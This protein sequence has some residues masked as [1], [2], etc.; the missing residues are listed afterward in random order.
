MEGV[1]IAIIFLI[2]FRKVS[3]K[4]DLEKR[5]R[6]VRLKTLREDR[7]EDLE[8][9]ENRQS[10]GVGGGETTGGRG[11]RKPE[12]RLGE[13]ETNGGRV[14][15]NGGKRGA[16]EFREGNQWGVYGWVKRKS[17]LL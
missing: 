15:D 12:S 7:R 11:K 8:R 5:F 4:R 10:G 9:M 6:Q 2:V 16:M 13:G 1:R 17:E 14:P 3:G